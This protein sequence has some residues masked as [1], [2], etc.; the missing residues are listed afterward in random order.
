MLVEHLEII[1]QKGKNLTT[2]KIIIFGAFCLKRQW[3]ALKKNYTDNRLNEIL[4][5]LDTY[6]NKLLSTG[7]SQRQVNLLQEIE[8]YIGSIKDEE[9]TQPKVYIEYVILNTTMDFLNAVATN[10]TAYILEYS[11][12]RNIDLINTFEEFLIGKLDDDF[13]N[14]DDKVKGIYLTEMARQL[15]DIELLSVSIKMD[16]AATEFKNKSGIDIFNGM[17]FG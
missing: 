3:E 8:E 15:K 11:P 16:Q 14:K 17:W 4:N 9:L 1:Q 12:Y 13:D 10:D 6:I 7:N 5:Q 2:A